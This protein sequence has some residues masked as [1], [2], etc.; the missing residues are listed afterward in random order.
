MLGKNSQRYIFKKWRIRIFKDKA[1]GSFTYF[2]NN[3]PIPVCALRAFKDA[4]LRFRDGEYHV[5]C[6]N[7]LSVMPV[8]IIL[9]IKGRGCPGGGDFIP[10]RVSSRS[11]S[12]PLP[13]SESRID[14]RG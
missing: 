13:L 14:K 4:V 7:R 12:G 10:R 8:D 5:G 2:F 11:A 1:Y 6:G 3:H 9:E